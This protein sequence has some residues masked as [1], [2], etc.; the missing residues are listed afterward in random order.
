MV[1]DIFIPEG[2]TLSLLE[3]LRIVSTVS[4]F[5]LDVSHICLKVNTSCFKFQILKII[6]N[7]R[8]WIVH[9]AVRSDCM[10]SNA[11]VAAQHRGV[12]HTTAPRGCRSC[13]VHAVPAVPS[14]WINGRKCL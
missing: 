14:L 6:L 12:S 13:T 7:P 8:I 2:Q 11:A 1:I 5:S 3:I 9:A 10:F 4:K